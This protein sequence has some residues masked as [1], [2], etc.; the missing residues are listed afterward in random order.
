VLAVLAEE[1]ARL[2]GV[3]QAVDD[4]PMYIYTYIYIHIYRER[5]R[6]RDRERGRESV[7]GGRSS[8]P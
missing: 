5:E 6:D 2:G 4:A 7:L 1:V 3:E 8:A